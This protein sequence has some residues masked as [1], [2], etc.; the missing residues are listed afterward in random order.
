ML[1]RRAGEKERSSDSV[2]REDGEHGGDVA[3]KVVVE[4]ERD[5]EAIAAPTLLDGRQELR[6]QDDPVVPLEVPD[7]LLERVRRQRRN[8]LIRVPGTVLHAV[9]HEDD[10]PLSTREAEHQECDGRQPLAQYARQSQA[11]RFQTGCDGVTERLL[12]SPS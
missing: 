10:A 6:R 11:M 2:P 7:L 9:I 12:A 4:G 8:E 5:R 1:E 3:A